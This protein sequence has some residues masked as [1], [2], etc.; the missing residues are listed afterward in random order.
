MQWWA[1]LCCECFTPWTSSYHQAVTYCYANSFID[2]LTLTNEISFLLCHRSVTN[3]CHHWLTLWQHEAITS[4]SIN[5]WGR[6]TH[7]CVRKIIIIGSDNGLSPGQRQAIIWTNAGILLIR[8]LG[9][10]FNEIL[11]GINTFS[12]NKRHVQMSSAKWRAFCLGLNELSYEIIA[13]CY[14]QR[15]WKAEA[16]ATIRSPLSFDAYCEITSWCDPAVGTEWRDLMI[17][18]IYCQRNS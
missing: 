11:L 14:S 5:F 13:K 9:I 16:P 4:C 3:H 8:P 18:W 1:E 15:K 10:N 7:I 2:N 12:F 6:M 17:S